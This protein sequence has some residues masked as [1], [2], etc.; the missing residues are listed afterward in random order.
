M[1]NCEQTQGGV[2]LSHPI[3]EVLSTKKLGNCVQIANFPAYNTKQ[4]EKKT[5]LAENRPEKYNPAF[6]S[7]ELGYRD[8]RD[9]I[10]AHREDPSYSLKYYQLTLV[11][12]SA[13]VKSVIGVPP[14]GLV[15]FGVAKS[16]CLG[17]CCI[18]KF[19]IFYIYWRNLLS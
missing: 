3:R 7:F 18:C 11:F 2:F 13:M 16:S 15:C 10:P 8:A 9:L 14:T 4:A 1:E 6:R 5:F 12:I 19:H 17:R